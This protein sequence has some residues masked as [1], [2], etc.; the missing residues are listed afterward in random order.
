MN[1]M[2]PGVFT[3]YDAKGALDNCAESVCCA[4]L[5]GTKPPIVVTTVQEAKDYYDFDSEL[6]ISTGEYSEDFDLKESAEQLTEIYR[7]ENCKKNT[8][9][10][11][12]KI[13]D[14]VEIANRFLRYISGKEDLTIK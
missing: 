4:S 1:D 9:K 8:P 11:L 6:I 10:L 3:Y 12:T 5:D 13:T 2:I 7:E 14:K